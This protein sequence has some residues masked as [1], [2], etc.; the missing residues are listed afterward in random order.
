MTRKA[1]CATLAVA[2]AA[3]L[4][5]VVAAQSD[6]S[7]QKVPFEFDKVATLTTTAGPVKVTSLRIANLG[8]GYSRGGLSLRS[9]NPPSELST[10]LRMTFDVQNPLEQEWEVTFTVE[11]MDK[12]G[13]VVDRATKK[14]DYED[15]TAA[16]QMEHPLL[17]YVLPFI[18][19]V[20][21]TVHGRRS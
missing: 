10:T 8:R 4:T 3:V 13:K 17:E 21:V 19:E 18:S 1:R 20:R 7:E 6:R 16:L 9:T 12:D 2:L 15:E 5:A 14:E 11:F